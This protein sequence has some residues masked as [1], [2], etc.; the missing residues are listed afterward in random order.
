MD[1]RG[2]TLLELLVTVT[3]LSVTLAIGVSSFQAAQRSARRDGALHLL[4]ASFA[5][6][7]ITAVS[8][9]VPV[10]VCPSAG[11]QQC[12]KSMAWENGWIIYLDPRREDSPRDVAQILRVEKSPSGLLI[13]ATA[14]RYRLRYLPSGLSSG[15]NLSLKLCSPSDLALEG[16]VVVGNTGRARTERPN[17]G[18]YCPALPG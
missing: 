6:A 5:T 2:Y 1:A 12:D 8:R 11:G 9:S 14:G 7:R 18:F 16:S 13:R 4:T 15:T 17:P 10:T 3:A